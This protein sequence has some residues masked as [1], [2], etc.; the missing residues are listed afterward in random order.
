MPVLI[1]AG[2]SS[3]KMAWSC[4]RTRRAV[5][6][7][8][9]KT[10]AGFCAVRHVTTLGPCTARAANVFRSAWMPAPPPLSEPAMVRATGK[11][12]GLVMGHSVSLECGKREAESGKTQ[13]PV[14]ETRDEITR[15]Q[16]LPAC[17]FC[18]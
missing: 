15:L 16:Y 3:E 7:C 4:C 5:A 17:L 2:G 18:A 10:P 1:A 12:R 13:P 11:R 9:P 6:A 14:G 8:T